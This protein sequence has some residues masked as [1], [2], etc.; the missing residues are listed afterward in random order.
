M[1]LIPNWRDVLARAW[2]VRL[3]LLAAVLSGVEIIL[4][5]I[6]ASGVFPDHT[7]AALSF[8]V[9]AGAFIA[10]FISQGIDR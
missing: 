5:F 6:G 1:R 8:L 9:V 2:S 10:R 3:M 4:P 7:F